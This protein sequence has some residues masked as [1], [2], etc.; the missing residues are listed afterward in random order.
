MTILRQYGETF[1]QIETSP[2]GAIGLV[3]SADSLKRIVLCNDREEVL[4]DIRMCFPQSR[5]Q[6]VVP[7]QDASVQLTQYFAGK[8]R[9]FNLVL[10]WQGLSDF[11]RRVLQQ[12][13]HLP[14]A[15]RTTYGEL[16]QQVGS[17]RAARAVGAVMAANP[18]VI[19]VPCHRVVGRG[20]RLGGYSGGSGIAVKEWLLEFEQ[21]VKSDEF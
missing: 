13:Q 12:L 10:D 6:A 2:V 16:A 17:P 4:E 8:R 19:V 20:G 18:F 7:L 21:R 1:Y 9:H 15:E 3:G 5:E 14:F 11:Q